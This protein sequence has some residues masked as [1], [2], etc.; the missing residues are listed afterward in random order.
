LAPLLPPPPDVEAAPELL[1]EPLLEPLPE[2]LPP[3]DVAATEL[4]PLDV[5]TAVL[6]PLELPLGVAP[7]E[8]PPLLPLVALEDAV[9][10]LWLP[11]LE[12][13]EVTAIVVPAA[14]Q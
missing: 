8:V 9:L 4:L 5:P 11:E 3:D 14:L 6:P 13:P 12:P 1:P 2:L 7:L 10:L